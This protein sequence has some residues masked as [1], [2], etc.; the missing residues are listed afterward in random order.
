LLINYTLKIQIKQNSP[1]LN[2]VTPYG[3]INK[4]F[5][6]GDYIFIMKNQEEIWK[7]VNGF[8]GIYFISNLGNVKTK[9]RTS[10]NHL[11]KTMSVFKEKIRKQTLTKAGYLSIILKHNG[12]C[13]DTFIHRLIAI[14]FIPNPNNYPVV[15]HI[16]GNPL[17]N[18]IENLEWCTYKHNNLHSF[19]VLK[20]KPSFYSVRVNQLDMDGD[21]ICCF[22]SIM[23]A[24]R[25][26]IE[27]GHN[28]ANVTNI[29]NYLLGKSKNA[30]GFK[31]EYAEPNVYKKTPKNLL[32]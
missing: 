6:V 25:A 30:Y 28:K 19:R 14:A 10:F 4:P 2:V 17:N 20:R 21:F 8:G 9:G 18:K 26:M 23:D 3:V 7:Q 16:D 15:N 13:Y 31:W 32:Q 22:N 27:L 11:T 12:D 29:R 1:K 5:N 24:V